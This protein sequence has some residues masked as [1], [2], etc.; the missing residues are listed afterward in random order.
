MI[1]KIFLV[2]LIMAVCDSLWA[3]D[4]Q[5]SDK[6]FSD[7]EYFTVADEEIPNST[8]SR[9]ENLN[10]LQAAQNLISNFPQ[11]IISLQQKIFSLVLFIH[12]QGNLGLGS[13]PYNR[14]KHFGG[15]IHDR[16][17]ADCLNTRARV[18]VRDSKTDVTFTEKGCTVANGTWDEP[19][20]GNQITNAHD[21]QIDHFV[22][23]KNAYISGA[24]AWNFQKRC[25]YANF[26][27]N[28]FHLLAVK[29]SE[30][31]R[32]SDRD[33]EGYMPP[34]QAYSCQ[35]LSQWLKVK[36][37]WNLALSASEK[38]AVQ[39]LIEQNHCQLSDFIYSAAELSQQRAFMINNLNLCPN[40]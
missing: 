24:F 28:N 25:L 33:P 6:A 7:H 12:H 17:Q 5:T 38:G 2:I 16:S 10:P 11:S 37:I 23:L 8:E 36:L 39:S 29:D 40:R 18:L 13:E 1:K 27:G 35:Y 15:W 21:I 22:P 4:I 20:T 34:N 19:Y 3:Q 14:T 30:N 31:Q 26:L 32:K 9:Q